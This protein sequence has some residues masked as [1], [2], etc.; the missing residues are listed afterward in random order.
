[1]SS[2]IKCAS[3]EEVRGKID[4]IDRVIVSLI[5]QRGNFVSQAAHVKKNAYD[6]RAPQRVEQVISKIRALSIELNANA[7]VVEAAYRAMI[8]AFIEAEL[9][10]QRELS[11]AVDTS[12]S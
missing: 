3:L 2:K 4:A 5:A 11:G 12:P 8:S 9:V 7:D 10:E 6:V 1:M